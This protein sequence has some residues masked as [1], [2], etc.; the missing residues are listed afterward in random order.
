MVI[1]PA[2]FTH[3]WT[4]ADLVDHFGA[5]PLHRIRFE[6][7]PGTATEDD[8][9]ALHD[10]ENRLF[11]LVDGVLV[12]K[13]VGFRESYLALLIAQLLGN[14][15]APHHLGIILGADGAVRLA[16]GLV[17][18]PDVSFFSWERL[19]ERRIP[20][21]PIPDLAPDLAVEVLSPSNTP[22][23]MERKRS[24]YFA[25]GVQVVWMV[26]PREREVHIYTAADHL[27]VLREDQVLDGTPVLPGFSISLAE[28]F[29]EP[30]HPSGP[31]R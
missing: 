21:E 14:F 17:R 20:T 12:E 5:M 31:P 30:N 27:T 18:I 2:L 15:V 4:A 9:I 26:L 19:P 25:A 29:A 8:V 11:E 23:E 24:D 22:R 13:T 10:R 16:P 3:T 6:P 28:L 7:F 1:S